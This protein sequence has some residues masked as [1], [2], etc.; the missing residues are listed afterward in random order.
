[1]IS[2][3]SDSPWLPRNLKNI[4]NEITMKQMKLSSFIL[5]IFSNLLCFEALLIA[6]Q[7]TNFVTSQ[8]CDVMSIK[9]KINLKHTFLFIQDL[10]LWSIF[11]VYD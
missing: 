5:D 11:S 1:V 8:P 9:L 6:L 4:Q 10:P 3:F 7:N 2:V